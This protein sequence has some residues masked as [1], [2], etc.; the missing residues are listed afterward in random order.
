L[1]QLVACFGVAHA[2]GQTSLPEIAPVEKLAAIKTAW[3]ELRERLNA[4]SPSLIIAVSND[5]LQNFFPVQPQFC[6]GLADANT[7]PAPAH[8]KRLRLEPR[9]FRGHPEFGQLLLATADKEKFPLSHSEEL[10][11]IDE[12]AIPLHFLV[13]DTT[14]PILPILTNCL[15][16]NPP[17]PRM[18]YALGEVIRRAIY[19]ANSE[20]RVAVIA[21]GGLSHDP[22]GPNWGLI[23]EEFDRR[24]LGLVERGDRDAIF[25][26]F[27]L[28]RIYS[29]GKGGTPETLNWFV[30]LG[31]AGST[32]ADV[33]CYEP[34]QE[35]A[36]GMGYVAWQTPIR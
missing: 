14:I 12:I 9:S 16:R 27:T 32:S 18:F 5:H 35:W 3:A 13:Q 2:P 4:A 1:G 17:S 29:A 11:F 36:T 10:E 22:Q 23:D 31:V 28:E 30:G 33:I 15:Y 6:L 8:S 24:F 20:L 34:V 19:A 7:F 25:R 21:T 26:E